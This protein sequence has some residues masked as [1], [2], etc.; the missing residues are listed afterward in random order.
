MKPIDW[1]RAMEP[2]IGPKPEPTGGRGHPAQ[3]AAA[4]GSP[5]S[6]AGKHPGAEA[7]TSRP[8]TQLPAKNELRFRVNPRDQSVSVQVI[9]R[10]TG[11]IVR[12][13]PGKGLMKAGE[14]TR[15]NKGSVV[16]SMA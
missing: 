6:L 11:T 10:E 13:I 5:N 2:A 14:T 9:D 4:V 1:N 8:K 3:P 16:N 12:E 15:R 7:E